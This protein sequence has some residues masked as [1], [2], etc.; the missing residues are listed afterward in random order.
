MPRSTGRPLNVVHE[1]ASVLKTIEEQ[2]NLPAPTY[3]DAHA[4]SVADFLDLSPMSFLEPPELAAPANPLPGLLA[5]TGG[6]PPPPPL[7]P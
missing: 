7:T 3:R 1:H 6:P 4:A 2:W 5:S